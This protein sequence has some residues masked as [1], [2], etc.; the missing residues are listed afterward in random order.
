MYIGYFVGGLFAPLTTMGPLYGRELVVAVAI[1][2]SLGCSFVI[3]TK[4]S[5]LRYKKFTAVPK[6][7]HNAA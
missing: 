3:S 6:C 5:K 2:N 7:T 1:L 4:R